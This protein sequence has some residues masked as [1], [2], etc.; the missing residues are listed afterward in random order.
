M[1]SID[2]LSYKVKNKYLFRDLNLKVRDGASIGIIGINGSGK[3][4]LLRIIAG[5]IYDYTGTVKGIEKKDLGYQPE[6][7]EKKMGLRVY[8][9][10][11]SYSLIYEMNQ[12]EKEKVINN[13]IEMDKIKIFEIMYK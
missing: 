9:Y 6:K 12:D 5:L 10:L 1:I 8:D 11:M 7:I 13:V 2:N 4:T 3:T